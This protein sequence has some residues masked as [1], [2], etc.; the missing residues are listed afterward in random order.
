M[1]KQFTSDNFVAEALEVSK[2]K[3]VLVDFFA[4][5]CGPCQMQA[6]ILDQV[7]EAI[8]DKAVVGKLNVDEAGDVAQK[9]G[10]MSIPTLIIFKDGKPAKQFVG[11]QM[12]DSLLADLTNLA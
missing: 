6:P 7:S 5:W 3:P 11:V 12:K 8:G 2:T 1:T 10:V 9:F 4:V